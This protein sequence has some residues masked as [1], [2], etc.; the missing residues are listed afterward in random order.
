MKKLVVRNIV[1][2]VKELSKKRF[3]LNNFLLITDRVKPRFAFLL[4]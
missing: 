2:I 3:E 4:L 1:K